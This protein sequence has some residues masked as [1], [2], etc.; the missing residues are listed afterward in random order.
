MST[1]ISIRIPD[2]LAEKLSE[3]SSETERPKSFLIQKA[4]E[5]YLDDLAD[6]QVA[7]DRLHDTS[8]PVVSLSDMRKELGL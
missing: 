3:I 1:S 6:L 8:D 7:L 2:E 4:L 5:A